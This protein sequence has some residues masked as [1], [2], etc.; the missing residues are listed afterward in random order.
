MYPIIFIITA[1][2]EV[3]L[4]IVRDSKCTHDNCYSIYLYFLSNVLIDIRGFLTAV[5]YFHDHDARHE[6]SVTR[7][8]SRLMRRR[9]VRFSAT[10]E[11]KPKKLSDQY[12]EDHS[13][14]EGA[15]SDSHVSFFDSNE[16]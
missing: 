14:S 9:G 16:K 4:L 8:R 3:G 7:I 2:G 6:L 12:G 5:L 10:D 1:V 11:P 15:Q 13:D